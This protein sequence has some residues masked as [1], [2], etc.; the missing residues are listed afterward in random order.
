MRDCDDFSL[1][2][3]MGSIRG[4]CLDHIMVVEERES[5]G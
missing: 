3:G 2:R 4:E 5:F 1:R